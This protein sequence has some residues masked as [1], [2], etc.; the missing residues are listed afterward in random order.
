MLIIGTVL[1]TLLI[2]CSC[3]IYY[4]ITQVIDIYEVAPQLAGPELQVEAPKPKDGVSTLK[5]RGYPA[6]RARIE[7]VQDD[8]AETCAGGHIGLTVD[9]QNGLDPVTISNRICREGN[10]ALEKELPPVPVKDVTVTYKCGKSA[11]ITLYK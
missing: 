2:I 7:W 4:Y 11:V 8:G 6:S 3:G 9:F 1:F 10:C 5:F